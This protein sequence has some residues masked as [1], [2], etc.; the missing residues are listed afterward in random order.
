MIAKINCLIR[1]MF[2]TLNSFSYS[3]FYNQLLK[4]I[5]HIKNKSHPNHVFQVQIYD[6]FLNKY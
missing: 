2:L 3:N 5:G 6:L 1:G 4:D